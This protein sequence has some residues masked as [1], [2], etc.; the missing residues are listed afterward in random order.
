MEIN[1]ENA[2]TTEKKINGMRRTTVKK[3]NKNTDDKMKKTLAHGD[4]RLEKVYVS[5]EDLHYFMNTISP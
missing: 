2:A 4:S 3:N 1:L 5:L